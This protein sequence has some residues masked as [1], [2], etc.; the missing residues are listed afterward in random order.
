M[1]MLRG[2]AKNIQDDDGDPGTICSWKWFLVCKMHIQGNQSTC[3]QSTFAILCQEDCLSHYVMTPC[4]TLFAIE[5]KIGFR[6]WI[7]PKP[8]CHLRDTLKELGH[9]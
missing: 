3:N 7:P 2:V 5:F 9:C 4:L 8:V 1:D 6:M